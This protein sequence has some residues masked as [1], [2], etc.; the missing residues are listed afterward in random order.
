MSKGGRYSS[1]GGHGSHGSAAAVTA[2]T[3]PE[4]AF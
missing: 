4:M 3:V 1:R 2:A